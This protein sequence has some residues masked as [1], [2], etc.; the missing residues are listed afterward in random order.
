[1]N[2]KKLLKEPLFVL[3]KFH[4]LALFL[5]CGI[6]ILMIEKSYADVS[7]FEKTIFVILAGPLYVIDITFESW[8]I[9]TIQ[10]KNKKNKIMS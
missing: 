10:T 5:A 8:R 1:M 7:I 6:L 2:K 3:E 9:A 4:P